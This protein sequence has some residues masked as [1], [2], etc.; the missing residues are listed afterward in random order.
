MPRA[1]VVPD[2]GSPPLP[3]RRPPQT[4]V[5]EWANVART[6]P[7]LLASTVSPQSTEKGSAPAPPPPKRRRRRLGLPAYPD[8]PNNISAIHLPFDQLETIDTPFDWTGAPVHTETGVYS[9]PIAVEIAAEA[10][11][12]RWACGLHVRNPFLQLARASLADQN[13]ES[14]R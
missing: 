10:A 3:T 7:E 9:R 1:C 6:E 13:H 12:F 5:R 8:I 14:L 11:E 4:N 2:Q